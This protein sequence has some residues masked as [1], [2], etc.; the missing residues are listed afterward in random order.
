MIETKGGI[1]MS[2]PANGFLGKNGQPVK[3]R[4]ELAVKEALD[5]AS[6]IR[7]DFLHGPATG[8]SKREVCFSWMPEK[9]E[10]CS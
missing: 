3:G 4:F 9:M 5:P 7:A 10:K 6:I 2:V 8:C 1:V